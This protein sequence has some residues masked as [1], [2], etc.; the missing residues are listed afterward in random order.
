[1]TLPVSSEIFAARGNT[2][3]T[4]RQV[5][6]KALKWIIY[7]SAPFFTAS[8]GFEPR[9]P[10]PESGVLPL[11]EEASKFKNQ[12]NLPR[13]YQTCTQNAHFLFYPLN[14]IACNFLFISGF[15]AGL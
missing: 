8:Q 1:V 11:N 2:T 3:G 9:Y 4:H 6:K 10:D 7:L 14:P 15:Q 13:E 12:L 5:V